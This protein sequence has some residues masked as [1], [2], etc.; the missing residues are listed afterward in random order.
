MQNNMDCMIPL[1]PRKKLYICGF[2]NAHS[3]LLVGIC[4][5]IEVESEREPLLLFI[6]D[7]HL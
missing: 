2:V 5:S 7:T 1:K 3:P 6:L 4:V